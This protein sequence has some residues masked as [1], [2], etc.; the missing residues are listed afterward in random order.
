MTERLPAYRNQ[1]KL[2]VK[3]QS[4]DH[5]V[6][7][8]L[9]AHK[10]FAGDYLALV[11]EFSGSSDPWAIADQLFDFCRKN[12][13][14]RVE[15]ESLQTTK[16]PAAILAHGH[17]DCKHYAG[18]IAGVVDAMNRAGRS[19]IPWAYRFVSYDF[20]N[21]DPVHVFV[22]LN[23]GQDEIWVDPVLPV[24]DTRQPRPVYSYDKKPKSMPLVRISG[25]PRRAAVGS[26]TDLFASAFSASTS[27]TNQTG[28]GN[29]Y[30]AAAKQVETLANLAT[31]QIPFLPLVKGLFEQFFGK[32]GLADWLSPAGILNEI[33]FAIFGRAYRGGQY[34]LGEKFRFYVLGEDIHTRDADVVGDE[35][36][37]TAITIFSVGFGVPIE[38]YQDILNLEQGRDAYLN[39]WV[40]QLGIP[41]GNISI[42]AVDRA[43]N[44]KRL[45]FP[46]NLDTQRSGPPATKWDLNNFNKIPLVA[47]IPD[48][49]APY[50]EIWTRTYSGPIPGG[51]VKNGV[52][53]AGPLS[54]GSSTLPTAPGSGGGITAGTWLLIGGAVLAGYLILKKR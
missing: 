14:Y 12:I 21:P 43:V 54:A 7:E 11:D 3:N 27:N 46:T 5:I 10:V 2:I 50:N 1:K 48:F 6:R 28:S 25:A 16:S 17:G 33:K 38:D 44:L 30:D 20:L 32:G 31:A 24:L 49:N 29:T 9:D 37:R 22:V 42:P 13:A 40:N 36:V 47:P 45:Y 52:V 8:V 51:E 4:T 15:S 18:F 41:A 35:A 19:R 53:I 34:W 26:F 23:P 39:R